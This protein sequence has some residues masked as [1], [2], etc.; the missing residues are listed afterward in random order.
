[1]PTLILDKRTQL[2]ETALSLFY[3][4]GIHAVGINEVLKTSGIAKKTLY[5]YFSSKE[6]L[7]AATVE[8]RSRLFLN[9]LQSQIAEVD[10]GRASIER[11]FSSLDDW[12]NE[13]VELLSPF[14]GCFFINTSAEYNRHDCNIYGQC[15]THK[16]QVCELLLQQCRIIQSEEKAAQSLNT[17]L[18]LLVEG[19]IVR[20][21]V[22][23]DKQAAQQAWTT[24]Q[25]LIAAP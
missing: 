25:V 7:I 17:S 11:I 18:S 23:G 1:M 19:A 6:E 14:K 15:R 24:A 8:Y 12:I 20:A 21:H 4:R 9:W 22:M 5:S 2:I 13:R 10:P 16:Q 3:E